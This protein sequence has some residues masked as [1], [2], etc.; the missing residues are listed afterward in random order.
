[1]LASVAKLRVLARIKAAVCD[2][3]Q[4]PGEHLTLTTLFKTSL[5][6]CGAALACFSSYLPPSHGPPPLPVS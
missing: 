1:M 4:G 3:P 6:P 5:G 2:W